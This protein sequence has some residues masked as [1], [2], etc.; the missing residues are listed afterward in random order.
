MHAAA[1]AAT[2]SAEPPSCE[3]TRVDFS[4]LQNASRHRH[5]CHTLRRVCIFNGT[6]MPHVYYATDADVREARTVAETLIVRS[7]FGSHRTFPFGHLHP[8]RPPERTS[9]AAQLLAR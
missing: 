6:L 3:K 5:T 4:G 1:L 9:V 8:M 7:Q 2:S